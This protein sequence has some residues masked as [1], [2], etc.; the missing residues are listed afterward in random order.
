MQTVQQHDVR[1]DGDE[2][3]QI[4]IIDIFI[5]IG[6]RK[7]TFL[8]LS[9]LGTAIF[10]DVALTEPRYYVA[11]TLMLIPQ[12]QQQGG[13]A[14]LLA[15]LGA[16]AGVGGSGGVQASDELFASLLKSR[17]IK[18]AL[19]GQFN[20]TARYEAGSAVAAQDVLAQRTTLSLDK[21]TGLLTITVDDL[22]AKVAAEIANAYVAQL[23]ALL[24]K[25]AITQ[26]QQRVAGLRQAVSPVVLRSRLRL[27]CQASSPT[28]SNSSHQGN[29][30][31]RF[32]R[33]TSSCSNWSEKLRRWS[34]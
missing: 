26:A 33:P 32:S 8:S 19:V 22:D 18:E 12:Q 30:R 31:N 20:L 3:K 34:P 1:A 11:T 15:Q 24:G 27:A 21:K 23:Q 4:S 2:P 25:L 16:L 13:S 6:M 10:L 17:K 5:L 28:S 14:L 29:R 9:I 7:W